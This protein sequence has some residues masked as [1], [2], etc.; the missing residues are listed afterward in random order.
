MATTFESIQNTLVSLLESSGSNLQTLRKLQTEINSYPK[1]DVPIQ[2]LIK[3]KQQLEQQ[4]AQNENERAEIQ[5][6]KLFGAQ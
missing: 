5:Q 2:D 6:L 1:I 3:Q 4:I